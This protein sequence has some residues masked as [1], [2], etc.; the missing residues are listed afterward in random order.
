MD[1]AEAAR[2]RAY[3]QQEAPVQGPLGVRSSTTIKLSENGVN[4]YQSTSYYDSLGRL[5]GRTD[6][7]SHDYMT[8]PHADPHYHVR[9]VNFGDPSAPGWKSSDPKVPLSGGPEWNSNPANGSN[10]WPGV[11]PW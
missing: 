9:N 1:P 8:A 10:W 11:Y 6:F 2:Y 5:E 7:T 3:W 4:T